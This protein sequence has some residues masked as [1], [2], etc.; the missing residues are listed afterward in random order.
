[1]LSYDA[2]IVLLLVGLAAVLVP[3]F[4][5]LRG[6]Y[7]PDVTPFFLRKKTDEDSPEVSTSDSGDSNSPAPRRREAA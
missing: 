7:T 2:I 3:F 1:M 5:G 6:L 4:G